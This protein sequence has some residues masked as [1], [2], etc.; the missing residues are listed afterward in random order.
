MIVGTPHNILANS[1]ASKGRANRVE[2]VVAIAP[3]G[4]GLRELEPSKH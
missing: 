4:R 2:F 1:G 3:T